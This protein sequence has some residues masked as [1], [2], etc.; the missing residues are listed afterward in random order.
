MHRDGLRLLEIRVEMSCVF[1]VFLSQVQT[2]TLPLSLCTPSP[3]PSPHM[4]SISC[5]TLLGPRGARCVT[6]CCLWVSALLIGD[7][8]LA[9]HPVLRP[10]LSCPAGLADVTE[11]SVGSGHTG[12]GLP[13]SKR[14]RHE[15]GWGGR[16]GW[17]MLAVLAGSRVAPH[18]RPWPSS[19]FCPARSSV[20]QLP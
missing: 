15:F 12:Q 17:A 13:G 20:P 18:V 9:C 6:L 3:V 5:E 4:P 16:P 1:R 7:T 10:F 14:H 19:A 2:R 11:G 8:G